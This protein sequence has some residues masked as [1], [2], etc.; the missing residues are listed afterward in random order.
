MSGI[1]LFPGDSEIDQIF[2]I[3]KCV[4]QYSDLPF[5]CLT[6]GP[7]SQDLGDSKRDNMA[8]GVSITRLQAYIPTMESK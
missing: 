6:C 8:W 3:F 2:K 5:V 4:P 1:P 7:L